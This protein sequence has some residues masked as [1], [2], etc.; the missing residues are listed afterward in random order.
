MSRCWLQVVGPSVSEA[1]VDVELV[2]R[3]PKKSWL[4]D[5]PAMPGCTMGS[6]RAVWL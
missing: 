3:L 1:A 5:I 2:E 6:S 4:W